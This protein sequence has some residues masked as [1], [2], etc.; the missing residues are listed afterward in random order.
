MW[1]PK[2]KE[3]KGFLAFKNMERELKLMK[4]DI[5]PLK[6][7]K[8]K[9]VRDVVKK[10]E[11]MIIQA[12][13]TREILRA[14]FDELELKE[15]LQETEPLRM[16]GG[17][18]MK[19]MVALKFTHILRNPLVPNSTSDLIEFLRNEGW[20]RS[21]IIT[22]YLTTTLHLW[23]D[24]TEYFKNMLLTLLNKK[25]FKECN[26]KETDTLGQ[27]FD[28]LS[29]VVH[30]ND[31]RSLVN[32]ELRNI[33]GHNKWWIEKDF[34]YYLDKKKKI[35][36]LHKMELLMLEGILSILSLEFISV[37]YDYYLMP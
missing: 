30:V 2:Q 22:L 37:L 27:V 23:F 36:R 10:A 4:E 31:F 3:L 11:E 15:F 25:A 33:L 20:T 14:F 9:D 1:N 8:R 32:P 18:M 7:S 28:K 16:M 26:I 6:K 29:K 19:N 21:E 34:V 5:Q 17:I 12:S 24:Q 13:R 35:K